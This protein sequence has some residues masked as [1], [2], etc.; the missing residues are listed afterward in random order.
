MTV[1][2]MTATSSLASLTVSFF[3]RGTDG[4]QGLIPLLNSYKFT[5]EENTTIEEDV[6]L[7]PELLGRVFENLLAAYNPETEA[8]AREETG[9][10]YTPRKIVNYMTDESLVAYLKD[11]LLADNQQER[12]SLTITTP[13][14]QQSLIGPSEAVQPEFS[15]TADESLGESQNSNI[16]KQIR[17]LLAYSDEPPQFTESEI[18]RLMKAID[19]LSVLDPAVGSGAFPMAMLQKLTYVLQRLDPDNRR[20]E[21][22]QKERAEKRAKAAFNISNQQERDDEL[23]AISDT[24]E[25]YRDSDFGRK[26]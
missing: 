14:I 7:D 2:G 12:S 8:S 25:R 10:Y 9:S 6:A 18:Q 5:V 16:E 3:Q 26:L 15:V 22:L 19:S 23:T 17:V 13:P 1:L 24:F 20:W 4:S 21:D 11:A